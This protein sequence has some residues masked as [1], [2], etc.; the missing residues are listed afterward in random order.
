MQVSKD[1]FRESLPCLT[2]EAIWEVAQSRN[3]NTAILCIVKERE[4]EQGRKEERKGRGNLDG[5][6]EWQ[7]GLL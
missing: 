7:C 4:R 6:H 2:D 5:N 3:K 1:F